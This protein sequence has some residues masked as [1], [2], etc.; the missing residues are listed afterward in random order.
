MQRQDNRTLGAKIISVLSGPSQLSR[1]QSTL[2][3][4]KQSVRSET[5]VSRQR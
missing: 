4:F 5:K 2:I 1:E 3:T